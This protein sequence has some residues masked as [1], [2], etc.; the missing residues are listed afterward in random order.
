MMC[1]GWNVSG[2]SALGDQGYYSLPL[3]T[4]HAANGAVAVVAAAREGVSEAS[5]LE[6]DGVGE[7]V[8]KGARRRMQILSAL[9]TVGLSAASTAIVVPSVGMR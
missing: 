7:W 6:A 2:G 8:T 4:D 3:S 1:S 5:L 9:G